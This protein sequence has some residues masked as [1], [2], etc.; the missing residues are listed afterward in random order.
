MFNHRFTIKTALTLLLVAVIMNA[1]MLVQSAIAQPAAQINYQGKLTDGSGVAVPDGAYNMR[2]WLLQSTN[3]ATTSAVWN[4]SLTGTEQV[5]VVNGL[6][7]VMLGSTSPLTAVDF[8]QPLYLGIEIG[9]TSGTPTWD[10]EM[11]P[12]KP[13]GTVPAAFEAYQV[14][15]VASSSLL[16]SDQA[17][18]ATGLLTFSNGIISTAS[19][20]ISDLTFSTAT[21]TTL[22]LGDEQFTD[23]TGTGLVNEAGVLSVSSSSL[24]IS[25]EGLTDVTAM[26]KDLG[27]LL[28]WNGT[29]WADIATSS[30]GIDTTADNLADNSLEELQDV[31]TM[32]KT[33]GD[34][35]Y[36]NGTEWADIA[37]SSLG[38]G[39]GTFLGLSDTPA[40]YTANRIMFTNAGGT[41]L[42]DTANFVFD[43]TNLGIGTSSP[44]SRLTVAGN[45]WLDSNV[46]SF[47]SSSASS[48]LLQYFAEATSTIKDNSAFA[49]TIATSTTASPIF[50]I[51]TSGAYPNTLLSGSFNVNNGA[52]AY[53]AATDQTTIQ[54]L[55]L[56]SLSFGD[57]AGVV[58]WTDIGITSAAATGTAMSY[59]ASLDGNPL[60]TVYGEADGLGGL[61]N[62]AIGVGTTS[63][64]ARFSVI[65]NS[66]D[67]TKPL[68]T[69]ASSTGSTLF[70]IT[71]DGKVGIG[72]TSPA[73][74]LAVGGATYVGGSL[75]TIGAVTFTGLTGGVLTTNSA[76]V[77]ATTTIASSTLAAGN[78]ANGL[79]LQASTTAA[80]GFDW[81]ATTTLGIVTTADD[82][83]DNS[84]EDLSDVATMTKD[85]GDLL[86][87]NGTEWAD[88]ATSSLGLGN[89]TF[90]GL[91]DT[92]ASY[93]ANRIMFTNA[94]GTALTDT[95]NFV[96]DGTNLGIGTSSPTA[97]LTL[98]TTGFSGAGTVGI[99]Q[100]LQTEN[101]VNGA[102]QFGNNFYLHASNTATTTLVGSMLR[103]KDD[104]TFANT[105]RGLEIQTNRGVNTYG[106]NT[107]LSA[108]ART[109]GVRAVTS[110]DAGAVFEPAAGFFETEGTTQGNAM[111]G[112][113]DTITTA[114]LLALF[115]SSSTFAG[116]GLEMNFGNG[117]GSFSSSTSKYLDFQ[118]GGNSV[119]TV[120]AFGTTT[121]G[122]GT[123]NNMASLQIGFGG[124][125]VDNDGSCT[126]TSTG[127]VVA[128]GFAAGNSDLAEMY[129]SRTALQTGELVMMTGSLSV[130]RATKDSTLPILGVV[131]T[132][133]GL[134]IGSDDTSL[135]A[136]EQAYPIA[137]SGR[138]PVKL[139]NENGPIKR[140]DALMLS[141][142]PGVAMKATAT[143]TTIGIAL[144]DFDE[145]RLYSE[146][147]VNQF[148]DDLVDPVYEPI[149]TV[150][151]AR[152][153][154]GCYYSGGNAVG[155]APCI[156][157]SATTSAAM[158]AEANEIAEEESVA[159]QLQ[160]LRDAQSEVEI[161]A[162]GRAVQ[163]GQLVMFVEKGYRWLDNAQMA[164]LGVLVATSS[165]SEQGENEEETLFDRLVALANRF[166]DGVLSVFT[167][168]AERVE[169][170][171]LCVDG[172]C[173][174][175]AALRQ[176]LEGTEQSA[177]PAA[178]VPEEPS[179]P[180][181]SE[182]PPPTP[183]STEDVSTDI[184]MSSTTEETS[185]TTSEES[186]EQPSTNSDEHEIIEPIE[187]QNDSA[188]TTE[189]SE[190]VA[191]EPAEASFS[192]AETESETILPELVAPIAGE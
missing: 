13:L 14:G 185:P 49:F 34:L 46:I 80:S 64:W 179:G 165:V 81:V 87:W 35:L 98:E 29:E 138:V 48:L 23:F 141:T 151:D 2:F 161:L 113:S 36:W 71:H 128:D 133:P 153:D 102:V 76:G 1:S 74:L 90:L 100:Y 147:Y 180:A 156:P 145:E 97:K 136:G 17:D 16:R 44:S 9:G 132:K 62:S 162:D 30:L 140:G 28:Y 43:G 7:S 75:T 39:N 103:I 186:T 177:S 118:N 5:S 182:N 157:L 86:Y 63:P 158:V 12:R 155:E 56:G 178:L 191:I 116:T 105:V 61:Q 82:L 31:A 25:L 176:L 42:T 175:A 72:T 38:L 96:F 95:A 192:E 55:A 127:W 70:H 170:S 107:A 89:G 18:T 154:D 11:L 181:V 24:N 120:S 163:V 187:E 53:D 50:R 111:R 112:Y 6:F 4:E 123:T 54:N 85:L 167:L 57:D 47:A 106:E 172:V 3:Q 37:T 60:L 129:F 150:Y 104:T 171:E 152:I 142:L 88:I 99:N 26:T 108:F 130:D 93:T 139:S 135:T 58:S 83:S 66:I 190:E 168:K 160:A 67:A 143:G 173:I 101:S 77:L 183:D 125:C 69:I 188:V 10:G 114:S 92:P 51:D 8:N 15:G 91:S 20:T 32:T 146:T 174:D 78:W 169:T 124:I 22:V 45:A 65:G 109:F 149:F 59:T 68:L 134:T 40:S 126:A 119:F 184:E 144:E 159:K 84:L 148:G 115:H 21:G 73:A 19:S 33:L 79:I 117:A 166:V 121:I 27:D 164:A 110:G 41:A 122:D 52:I 131:S 137:L 189:E 94:G